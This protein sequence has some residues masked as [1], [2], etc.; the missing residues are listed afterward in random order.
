MIVELTKLSVR[1]KKDEL[2]GACLRFESKV[3]A[4]NTKGEVSLYH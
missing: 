4:L 2:F 3:I 1:R